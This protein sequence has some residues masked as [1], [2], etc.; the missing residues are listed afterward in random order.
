MYS[1]IKKNPTQCDIIYNKSTKI[2]SR[3]NLFLPKILTRIT[4]SKLLHSTGH[5]LVHNNEK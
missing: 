1:A 4:K 2:D 5:E 3:R